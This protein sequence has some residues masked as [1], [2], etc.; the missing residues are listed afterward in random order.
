MRL[1]DTCLLHLDGHAPVVLEWLRQEA[2]D[3][4]LVF[5]VFCVGPVVGAT[6]APEVGASF[7]G[8]PIPGSGHWIRDRCR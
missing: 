4:C 8:C 2:P 6:A 3:L 5:H 1:V 7:R